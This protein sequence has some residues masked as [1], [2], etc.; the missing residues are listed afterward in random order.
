MIPCFYGAHQYFSEL[1]LWEIFG[2]FTSM[3][4]FI[5][6]KNDKH[7]EHLSISKEPHG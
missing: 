7:K 6:R 1:V 3:K 5:Y 2:G 4:T